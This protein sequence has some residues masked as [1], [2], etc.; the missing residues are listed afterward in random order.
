ME[1]DEVVRRYKCMIDDSHQVSSQYETGKRISPKFLKIGTK[2]ILFG[3]HQ[4]ILHPVFVLKAWYILYGRLNLIEFCAITT[5]DLG[6]FGLENMDGEE[7]E[8]HP[9]IAACWWDG[10]L[11]DHTSF[12]GQVAQEII[13][14]SRFYAKKHNTELSKLFYADK[15]AVALY[16][17]WLYKLLGNLSGEIHEYINNSKKGNHSV[18]IKNGSQT[19]WIIEVQARMALMGLLGEKRDEHG[20]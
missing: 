13:G 16:P 15:L 20:S 5:H 17:V 9:E 7:G 18:H 12:S 14:H 4:F 1:M 19:K 2:S 11:L 8:R 6:Y 3:V 10:G